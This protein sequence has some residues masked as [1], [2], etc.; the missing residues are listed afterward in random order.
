MQYPIHKPDITWNSLFDP[1]AF[2]RHTLAD[3]DSSNRSEAPRVNILEN[4]KS[5]VLTAEVPGFK[6][7][8]IDIAVH[9]G[10][11]TLKG[12]RPSEKK[13]EK[14]EVYCLKEFGLG[15]FE[16]T[17]RLGE[18]IDTEN[19]AAKL[20]LGLLTITF[21]KKEEAQPKR[22]AIKIEA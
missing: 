17:F 1:D 5:F 16:R 22:I 6:E 3:F 2:I 20:E 7:S 14:T 21:P 8:D 18:H 13:E 15:Q 11:L 19:I 12:E 10:V 9:N 4:E